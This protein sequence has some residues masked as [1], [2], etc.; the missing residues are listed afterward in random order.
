MSKP[1]HSYLTLSPETPL[2][3]SEAISHKNTVGQFILSAN[4]LRKLIQKEPNGSRN[5]NRFRMLADFAALYKRENAYEMFGEFI[6]FQNDYAD[7]Q[8]W[9]KKKLDNKTGTRRNHGGTASLFDTQTSDPYYSNWMGGSGSNN[10]GGINTSGISNLFN[11]NQPQ[12]TDDD[13]LNYDSE[14]DIDDFEDLDTNEYDAMLV[15]AYEDVTSKSRLRQA[16]KGYRK[17]YTNIEIPDD[18]SSERKS[19]DDVTDTV[20]ND[21]KDPVDGDKPEKI[22]VIGS[23][24]GF[25]G[26]STFTPAA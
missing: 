26:I 6:K 21:N 20:T 15:Q 10:F 9:R 23:P 3:D 4:E 24:P 11:L 1:I 2:S 14:S 25:E 19:I 17:F 22:S 8:K 7:F 5:M 12:V 16:T 13:R 18:E